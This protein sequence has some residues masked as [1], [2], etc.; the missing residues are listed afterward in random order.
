M[1]SMR[2]PPRLFAEKL[3]KASTRW[4]AVRWGESIPFHYVS[5]HPKSGGTWL[6]RMVGDALQLPFPQHTVLPLGFRCVIQNHWRYD[7]RLS[8]VF[9][10]YRDGRD[11]MTSFYF[12][13]LRIARYTERPGRMMMRNTYE[14]L[15]GKGYDPA[16]VVR[17]MPRF[18]EYEFANP[19]RGTPLNWRDH[20]ADWY[21]PEGR[22]GIAYLSYEE[23][24]E[25]CAGALGRALEQIAGEPIDPWRIETT[26][27]K[28]SMRRQ[29]GR[30]PGEA[31]ISQH[32]RKG[33]VGDWRNH[34]SREAAEIFDELAGDALV[35]L[36]YEEDRGWVDRYAYPTA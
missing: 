31:D 18:I 3:A 34:F 7:P 33:V 26:V 25:D 11:V 27:E 16:D 13:R 10:L 2:Y 8:R 20:V 12:D 6:A 32:I 21:R 4:I 23:L 30:R 29:T 36:G 28:M 15:F 24:I 35:E 19:G 14:K 17:H 1:S 5:E 9:Y 22:D